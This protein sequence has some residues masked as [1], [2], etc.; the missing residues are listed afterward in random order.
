[1]KS[2]F[3]KQLAVISSAML[4]FDTKPTVFKVT[5]KQ[6]RRIPVL[7]TRSWQAMSKKTRKSWLRVKI[8]RKARN[9]KRGSQI[10]MSQ[11]NL[12]QL[13]FVKQL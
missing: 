3:L 8:Q 4:I 5:L 6:T 7:K 1:M 9:Q 2:R 12:A 13:V 11:M 10:S